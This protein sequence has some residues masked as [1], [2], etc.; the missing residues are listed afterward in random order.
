MDLARGKVCQ[1]DQR[2]ACRVENSTYAGWACKEC[3][4]F[5][6]P[7]TISRW[8]WHLVLLYQLKRAGY[9]FQANDLSLETWILLGLVQRIFE[10]AERKVSTSKM[11]PMVRKEIDR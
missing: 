4:E 6:R 1:G 11:H 8:T 5:R 7:E 2:Q 3:Q 10:A 9:P